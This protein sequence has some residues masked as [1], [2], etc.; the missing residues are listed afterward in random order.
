MITFDIITI[1]P[2]L[3]EP[4]KKEGLL[5][6]GIKKKLLSIK[7]H[8]LRD[9]TTDKHKTI[10][11]RPFGGGIGM[12]M[13]VEPIFKAVTAVKKAHRPVPLNGTTAGKEKKG[14]VILFTPRGKPFTQKMA[15]QFSKLDHL[16]F[17]CGR[18]EAVDERVA[19][20]LADVEVSMGEYVLMGGE[21]PA[22]A[23]M[24]S[25]ARLL[26]GVIGKPELLKERMTKGGGFTEYP[27]YTRPE[28]FEPKKGTKWRVPKM[29]L[30]GDHDKIE[31]WHKKRG[32][33]VKE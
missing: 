2:E 22:M 7:A 13:M 9:W 15:R 23:V 10:D 31:A 28:V 5:S 27:Q 6:R 33:I 3:F 24:E 29:L 8:N 25:V 21:V 20:H 32:K 18:Y 14:K 17:I 12:V 19:K 16:I 1:F 30:S 26:P 4:F 11:D